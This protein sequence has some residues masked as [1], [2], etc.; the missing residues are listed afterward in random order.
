[1]ATNLLQQSI[2][3][4]QLLLPSPLNASLASTKAPRLR[5]LTNLTAAHQHEAIGGEPGVMLN[6]AEGSNA[7]RVAFP[8]LS[9]PSRAKPPPYPA[10]LS[11]M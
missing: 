7:N 6:L 1:M 5:F 3:S 11:R 9:L 4:V 10:E 8:F 2:T